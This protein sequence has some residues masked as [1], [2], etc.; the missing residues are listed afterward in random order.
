MGPQHGSGLKYGLSDTL[1]D[2]S[3]TRRRTLF[4]VEVDLDGGVSA[5]IEDLTR[6]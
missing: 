6:R 2:G 5:R 4:S 1:N 3:K